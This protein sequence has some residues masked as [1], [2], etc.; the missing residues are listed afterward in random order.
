MRRPRQII[1]IRRLNISLHIKALPNLARINRQRLFAA[2]PRVITPFASRARD[3]GDRAVAVVRAVAKRHGLQR[4]AV[5][6]RP[7]FWDVVVAR[8]GARGAARHVEAAAHAEFLEGQGDE[9]AEG[10][11]AAGGDADAVFDGGPD[12]YADGL[13]CGGWVLVSS[14]FFFCLL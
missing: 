4:H 9:G 10:R 1:H 8:G 14:M 11:D 3:C 5:A 2:P 6:A 13:D 7:V 12:C